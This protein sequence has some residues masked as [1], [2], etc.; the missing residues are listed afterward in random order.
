MLG[1][2]ATVEK[3]DGQKAILDLFPVVLYELTKDGKIAALSTSFERIT[4]WKRKE[5]L[6]KNIT[7]LIHP[8][9]L[10]FA[11]DK[12]KEGVTGKARVVQFQLRILSKS[13]YYIS[14]E[15]INRPKFAK[16]KIVGTS[17]VA[18]DVT[19]N[20]NFQKRMVAQY[21]ISQVLTEADSIEESAERVMGIL[22]ETFNWDL[23][24]FWL[25]DNRRKRLTLIKI[26]TGNEKLK[27]EKVLYEKRY[28]KKGE[29]VLGKVW[30]RKKTIWV[31]N[32]FKS[33]SFIRR[34]MVKKLNLKSAFAFPIKSGGKTLAV[35]EFFSK[36]MRRPD[37]NTEKIVDSVSFQ[38]GQFIRH[39]EYEV[40]LQR[41][42]RQMEVL[43]QSVP[44]GITV[45]EAGGKMIFANAKVYEIF[46]YRRLQG[47]KN[48]NIKDLYSRFDISDI[49]GRAVN[50]A[51]LSAL[52]L[53]K[54]SKVYART[55]KF[56]DKK[57]GREIWLNIHATGMGSEGDRSTIVKVYHDVTRQIEEQKERELF[58]GFVSHEFRSPLASIK[59]YA[60]LLQRLI[61][62]GKHEQLEEYLQSIDNQTDK[63]VKLIN[64]WLDATRVRAG[65]L[66]MNLKEVDY[67]KL[68]EQVVEDFKLT[69]DRKITLKNAGSRRLY[70]DPDRISQVIINLLSNAVNNSEKGKEIV[71]EVKYT[72][73]DIFTY[74]KDEG[75]GIAKSQ[76]SEI[77]KLF[78]KSARGRGMGM[79]LYIANAIIK[80]HKGSLSV[81]SKLGKGSVFYFKLP[82]NS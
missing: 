62:A 41:S 13:G 72:K 11:A 14:W 37:G 10:E 79:G 56:K 21:L 73:T 68:L 30:K 33:P 16:G 8:D 17:G 6:G 48:I 54:S 69:V 61:N 15:F 18:R 55:H 52:K 29:G 1:E 9:D 27:K 71:V 12:F 76:Q 51:K 4:G 46:G 78:K 75:S 42:A 32:L 22:A 60:Q 3:D 34:S 20:L 53:L 19:E 82:I 67:P 45:E 70:L 65:I 40:E 63:L 2:I 39:K 24:L 77:F 49:A 43:F 80:A 66:R 36:D 58:I 50:V 44:D 74:V 23:G 59:A 28:F 5:W 81:K 25:K 64:N 26:W 31:S 38:I 57:T 47:V 35:V 7:E